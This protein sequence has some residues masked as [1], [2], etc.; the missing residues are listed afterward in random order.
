[1]QSSTLREGSK[2]QTRNKTIHIEVERKY[3]T[4]SCSLK[5][6]YTLNGKTEKKYIYLKLYHNANI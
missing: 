3:S 4:Q 2:K 6:G 5:L 1:M